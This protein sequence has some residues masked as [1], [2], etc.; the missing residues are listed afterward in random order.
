MAGLGRKGLTPL[1]GIVTDDVVEASV[2]EVAANIGPRG[3]VT[4]DYRDVWLSRE[5]RW[6][7]P[8]S[9]SVGLHLRTHSGRVL[10]NVES[11]FNSVD[12]GRHRLLDRRS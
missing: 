9:G 4:D 11:V 8:T 10:D 12:D 6:R 3:F 2:G 5:G 7:E 1:V